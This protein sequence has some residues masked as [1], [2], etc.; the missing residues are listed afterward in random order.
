MYD[1][2]YYHNPMQDDMLAVIDSMETDSLLVD[3][4]GHST[5]AANDKG[6]RVDLIEVDKRLQGLMDTGYLLM[7]QRLIQPIG[8][9][10][11]QV[12]L[13]PDEILDTLISAYT[14]LVWQFQLSEVGQYYRPSPYASRFLQAFSSSAYLHEAAFQ[15]P[16]VMSRQAANA[17]VNELNQRLDAWYR[18]MNEPSFQYEFRR[19]QRNSEKNYQRFWAFFD[20]LQANHSRLQIVRVDCE[21]TQEDSPNITHDIACHH[22]EQL[23]HRVRNHYPA[24]VGYLWKLEWGPKTG[25]HYHFI[26][27]FDGH[28]VRQDIT[29]GEQ[30]GML[31]ARQITGAQGR[32]FNC[33]RGA[34]KRYKH[35]A[36]GACNYHDMNKRIGLDN[37][38]RYLTKVDE[39]VVMTTPGRI[40]QTSKAPAIPEG[41]RPGRPRQF[42]ESW[43]VGDVDFP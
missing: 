40:F 10:S 19:N 23:C 4:E 36:L 28:Q 3:A 30:I 26:F 43:S 7:G 35:N 37:L 38:A 12:T 32:Y 34:E 14:V 27:F 24:L 33:N 6:W 9:N 31:W 20:A 11:D 42:A 39:Q 8:F 5:L 13:S 1:D 15:Q 41:P 2:S 21:Y 22:R 17:T 18:S 25:F 16:P 29:L